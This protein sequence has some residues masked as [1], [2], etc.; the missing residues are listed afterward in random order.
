MS[1]TKEALR[2]EIAD[3][4]KTVE[5]LRVDLAAR[6]VAGHHCG[7]CHCT[8]VSGYRCSGCGGWYHGVHVCWSVPYTTGAAPVISSYTIDPTVTNYSQVQA[9]TACANPAPTSYWITN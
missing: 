8:P 9:N 1:G 6:P 3:L 7:G 4:R 2:Q 5:A